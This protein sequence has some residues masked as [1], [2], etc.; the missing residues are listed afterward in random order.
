M[1]NQ[2]LINRITELTNQVSALNKAIE[3]CEYGSA[4]YYENTRL[5]IETE[6]KLLELTQHGIDNTAI[7]RE[8]SFNKPENQFSTL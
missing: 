3:E 7:T 5:L 2:Q 6:G 4:E 8:Y 1:N